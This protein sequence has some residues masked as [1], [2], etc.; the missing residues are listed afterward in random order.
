M[1]TG[2]IWSY[3]PEIILLLSYNSINGAFWEWS[4]GTLG[5]I[6]ISSPEDL[7][8]KWYSSWENW[9]EASHLHT[10]RQFFVSSH[11]AAFS[12]LHNN[13]EFD[14]KLRKE[15]SKIQGTR[16]RTVRPRLCQCLP[17][18][19]PFYYLWPNSFFLI[20]L[21]HFNNLNRLNSK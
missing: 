7:L 18:C 20:I 17:F 1:L 11:H 10:R 16:W 13:L 5:R 2:R 21:D 8:A 4:C 3:P 6:L 14:L 9:F 12:S 15:P 19:D